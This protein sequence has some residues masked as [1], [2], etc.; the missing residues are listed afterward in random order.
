M[1]YPPIFSI[2]ASAPAVL[3]LLGS[4]PVRLYLFG[5][6][7]QNVA[8]PYA[9]WQT[10]SGSPENYLGQTP[11]ADSWTTQVDCYAPTATSA[12]AVAQALRDAF[13]P[14]AYI[15]DWRGESRATPTSNFRVS[16]DVAW[17]RGRGDEEPDEIVIDGGSP[18]TQFGSNFDG[19]SP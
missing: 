6:A 9:V 10:V 17:I 15:T 18:D 13:E 14:R 16:F 4:N 5:E 1:I 8:A 19:G 2:A 12:R 11:D 7:P 3:A